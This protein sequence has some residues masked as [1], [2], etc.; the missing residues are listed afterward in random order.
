MLITTTEFAKKVGVSQRAVA[1]AIKVGRVPAYD[2]TGARVSLGAQGRVFVK[3]DEAA[4]AF[5][6]SRARIDDAAVAEIAAE[7]DRELSVDPADT[8]AAPL[9]RDAQ[10]KTPTLVGAKTEKEQLQAD[11]LRLRLDRERGELVSRQAQL[12]AFENIGRT[13][14]RQIQLMATWAEEINGVARQGGVPSLTAWL[15]AKANELCINI[16]DALTAPSEPLPDDDTAD[17]A[18]E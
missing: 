15:R 13:V 5:R 17:G 14:Q 6:L 9:A 1:K 7:I 11:L 3:D 12:D 2:E 16:A 4:A 8:L 10:G 18:E